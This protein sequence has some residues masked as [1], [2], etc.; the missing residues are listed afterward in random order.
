MNRPATAAH[1][2]QH[3]TLTCGVR[4]PIRR[5]RRRAGLNQAELAAT[6]RILGV[7]RYDRSVSSKIERGKSAM[8]IDGLAAAAEA[9]E[10][11]ADEL[12]GLTRKQNPER[13]RE[14]RARQ[15][16]A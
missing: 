7:S 11:S 16:V 4:D 5:R 13:D 8:R 2:H 15:R 10:V 3:G 6:L 1:G 9:M 12:L 14:M